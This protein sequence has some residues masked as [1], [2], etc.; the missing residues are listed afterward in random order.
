MNEM[1]I[2]RLHR[3]HMDLLKRK[4]EISKQLSLYSLTFSDFL[5]IT[6]VWLA[7]LRVRTRLKNE[8]REINAH[9]ELLGAEVTYETLKPCSHT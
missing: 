7:K 2:D 8:L 4:V 9:S 1:D 5:T 6:C 3:S